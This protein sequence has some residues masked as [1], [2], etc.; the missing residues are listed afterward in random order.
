[1]GSQQSIP[2]GCLR[3]GAARGLIGDVETALRDLE[4][5]GESKDHV[6]TPDEDGWT[7][8]QL[9]AAYGWGDVVVSES[10]VLSDPF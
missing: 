2:S 8:L 9:A 7:A 5:G 1:M 6:D 3:Q 10:Y 4:A